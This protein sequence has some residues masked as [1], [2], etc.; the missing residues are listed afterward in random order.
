MMMPK[1]NRA[2]QQALDS[3]MDVEPIW[4]ELGTAQELIG[5]DDYTLLHAGPPIRPGDEIAPPLHHSAILAT[6]FETWATTV[7][8]AAHLIASGRIQLRPAQ[9]WSV[10]T[11]LASV[12]SPSMVLQVIGDRHHSG[13]RAYSP[14]NGGASPALRFG[15]LD[16]T[17]VDRLRWLHDYL[18]PA[19]ETVLHTPID[20]I[21][22]ADYALASGNECHGMTAAGSEVLCKTLQPMNL[23]ADALTFIQASPTFFLNL[24]MAACKCMLNAASGV[25]GSSLITSMAGNGR[26]FG[27]ILSANPDRWITA[28]ALPPQQHSND[29]MFPEQYCG[30]IGDSAVIDALGLGGMALAYATQFAADLQA[31]A[32][33]NFGQLPQYLLAAE[34]PGFIASHLRVGLTAAAVQE[35]RMTPLINLAILDQQGIN[36][37]VGKGIYRPPLTLF[38]RAIAEI[39][40]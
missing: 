10:V 36:G 28:P 8:E 20:L 38:E 12:V 7:E 33:S 30:A 2:D 18:A 17:V 29:S 27:I 3:L 9:H 1:L 16:L 4:I 13:Y 40:A 34:H 19:F 21:P 25:K 6:L 15:T 23:A 11:P 26:E 14:L 22:I 5:L 39:D 35:T 37:M 32:P 24:W 31:I